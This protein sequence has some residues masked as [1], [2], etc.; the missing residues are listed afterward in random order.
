M[1]L[2]LTVV[3]VIVNPASLE[4]PAPLLLPS[5]VISLSLTTLSSTLSV[6]ALLP[7][8][9]PAPRPSPSPSIAFSV[10]TTPS[11]RVAAASVRSAAPVPPT[12][13]SRKA[14]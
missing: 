8:K 1:S 12:R 5:E 9:T 10:T 7:A 11:S 6:P 4:M 3:A 14:F 2:P 13:V